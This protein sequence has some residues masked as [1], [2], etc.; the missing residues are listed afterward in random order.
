MLGRRIINPANDAHDEIVQAVPI[1]LQDYHAVFSNNLQQQVHGR[2]SAQS[3]VHGCEQLLSLADRLKMSY[4][5]YDSKRASAAREQLAHLLQQQTQTNDR[6]ISELYDEV[7]AT[8]HSL[9]QVDADIASVLKA[10]RPP[11]PRRSNTT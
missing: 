7:N 4:I 8:L 3:L 9:E 2:A 11:P 1:E 10:T 6:A 5:L